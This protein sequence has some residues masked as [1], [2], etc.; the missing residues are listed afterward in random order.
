MYPERVIEE[1]LLLSRR[2]AAQ[3]L[4]IGISTMETIMRR[5]DIATVKV[6]GRRLIAV[7]DLVAYIAANRQER[8]T[9]RRGPGRP[10]KVTAEL[11]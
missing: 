10:R 6:G 4:G 8:I 3:R 2:Q 5:R 11:S 9:E 1:P 7:D